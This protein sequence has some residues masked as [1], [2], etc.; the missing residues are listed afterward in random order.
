[1]NYEEFELAKSFALGTRAYVKD[2]IVKG[3]Y[4]VLIVGG[5][6]TMAVGY[7]GSIVQ[8]FERLWNK[9]IKVVKDADDPVKFIENY[10]MV[11]C[12]IKSVDGQVNVYV[13]I[14][15]LGEIVGKNGYK[16]DTLR[17]ILK[18]RWNLEKIR[19]FGGKMEE[20]KK[21]VPQEMQ[22]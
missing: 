21:V 19:F 11:P 7:K 4:V 13:A 16:A 1:M 9:K 2:C 6:V 14:E 10:L 15:K 18:K 5:N 8:I 20:A 12:T 22:T 17:E 3:D